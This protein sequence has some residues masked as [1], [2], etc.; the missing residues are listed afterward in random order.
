MTTHSP[1]PKI[2]RIPAAKPRRIAT[3]LH[4]LYVTLPALALL[5]FVVVVAME[6]KKPVVADAQAA[7]AP[8]AAQKPSQT[9]ILHEGSGT[10]IGQMARISEETDQITEIHMADAAKQ[11]RK[12]LL[13]IVGKY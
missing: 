4:S 12:N 7:A 8:S 6:D 3:A 13:S 2:G 5:S 10:I 9:I 11:E 1:R